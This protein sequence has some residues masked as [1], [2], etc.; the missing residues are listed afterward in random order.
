MAGNFQKTNSNAHYHRQFPMKEFKT[1]S[2]LKKQSVNHVNPMSSVK[3]ELVKTIEK[4]KKRVV[5]E[6]G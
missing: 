1:R 3:S 2:G 4:E 6:K 5:K